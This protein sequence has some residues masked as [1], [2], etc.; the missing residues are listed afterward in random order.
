[1]ISVLFASILASAHPA[2]APSDLHVATAHEMKCTWSNA[3]GLTCEGDVTTYPLLLYVPVTGRVLSLALPP[4]PE[5]YLDACAVQKNS[6]GTQQVLCW[7]GNEA[8]TQVPAEIKSPSVVVTNGINA[9]ANSDDTYVRCWGSTPLGNSPYGARGLKTL[10][11]SKD[12]VCG[13]DDFGLMCWGTGPQVPENLAGDG[14][15]IDVAAIENQT[16]ALT[17]EHVV[18]CWGPS[19]V[20][21]PELHTPTAL[22]SS[23]GLICA[24]DANGE[25]CWGPGPKRAP[26]V[27]L[28]WP[29]GT[30]H[31]RNVDPF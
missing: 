12:T 15:A 29:P 9:C 24:T 6:D 16:C 31:G 2:T 26:P 1:M 19:T 21:V 8:V 10:V 27:E 14:V 20:A 7:G 11:M 3:P 17:F 22:S 28:P 30:F 18:Q 4:K 25:T 13:I 5:S 23:D